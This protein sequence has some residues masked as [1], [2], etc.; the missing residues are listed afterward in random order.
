[1]M[2]L[3]M[4]IQSC[5]MNLFKGIVFDPFFQWTMR[6]LSLPALSLVDF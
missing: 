5:S 3:L 1:M 2:V 6:P 4:G